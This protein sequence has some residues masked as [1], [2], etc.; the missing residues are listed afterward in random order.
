M[1]ITIANIGAPAGPHG[2]TIG[3]T[4]IPSTAVPVF[5]EFDYSE[6]IG[7]AHVHAD[8]SADLELAPGLELDVA[9]L[10]ADHTIGLGYRVLEEHQDG[11][12]RVIDRLELL[13]V[14]VSRNL[15]KRGGDAG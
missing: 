3:P 14:G 4:A 5:V 9:R 11:D 12:V 1:K 8:G 13:A 2:D 15:I 7:V 6:S 10:E